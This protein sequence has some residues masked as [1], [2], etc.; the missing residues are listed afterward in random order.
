MALVD[1]SCSV[2]LAKRS[3]GSSRMGR[4]YLFASRKTP[5]AEIVG[6]VPKEILYTNGLAYETTAEE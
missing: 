2:V 4:K 6:W 5:S 3:S 1:E